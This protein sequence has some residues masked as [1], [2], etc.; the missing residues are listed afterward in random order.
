MSS[1]DAA[2]KPETIRDALDRF[3][4]YEMH[5]TW[6]GDQVTFSGMLKPV[7][8]DLEPC[9]P[10]ST[11]DAIAAVWRAARA[12]IDLVAGLGWKFAEHPRV[13]ID[14]QTV[15]CLGGPPSFITKGDITLAIIGASITRRDLESAQA[16][17][18]R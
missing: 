3:M 6:P 4:W 9:V 8:R 12:L 2:G 1:E 14:G 5:S 13:V 18:A 16:I 17:S 15:L 10:E 11:D 7:G